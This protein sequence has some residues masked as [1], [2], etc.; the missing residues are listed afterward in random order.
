MG[1]LNKLLGG[2]GATGGGGVSAGPLV[3]DSLPDGRW[4]AASEGVY[5]KT[6][7]PFYGS[8]ET[9]ARGGREREDDGDTGV[10]LFFYQKS[11]DMLHTAYGFGQMQSR[12]PSPQDAPIL[13]GF[14]RML[15]ATL[16]AHPDAPV[17]DSVREVT[18][19]LRSISTACEGAGINSLL[20]REELRKIGEAAP[21][22]PVDDVRWT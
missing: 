3:D 17:G 14:L 6:I 18:H 4:L 12:Q 2:G 16:S 19:R 8:P 10:A 13:Y 9:M 20:Y 5:R 22:V 7:E 11:I 1:F 15:E 21:H